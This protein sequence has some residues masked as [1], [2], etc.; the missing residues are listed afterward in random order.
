MTQSTDPI[1]EA[2]LRAAVRSHLEVL[3]R[4]RG[5]RLSEELQIEHG[6]ARVDLVVIG[7]TIEAFEL[8]SDLDNFSRLH[9]QIHAYNRVFDRITIV[10]G[11]QFSAAALAHMPPWWGVMAATKEQDGAVAVSALRG[12]APNPSQEPM[13]V[14]MLLWRNEAM[15]ELEACT[16]EPAPKRATRL[17]L[18]ERL[19]E[20]LSLTQLR[21]SV[22]RRLR[23]REKS[24]ATMKRKRR[25]DSSHLDASCSGFHFLT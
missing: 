9:N 10:T 22:A 23:E 24:T 15:E 14:A 13:S 25:D 2:E 3:G 21:N 16:G 18:H 1:T 6:A 8:K 12:A 4:G 17:Q 7:D 19:T 5:T 11:A 20:A